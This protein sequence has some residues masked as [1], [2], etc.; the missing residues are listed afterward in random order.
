MLKLIGNENMKIY[1]RL[2]TWILLGIL[3]LGIILVAVVIRS[4]QHSDPNW[5]QTLTVS[6]AQIQ[7]QLQRRDNHIPAIG[8]QRMQEQIAVNQYDIQHNID[9]NHETAWTFVNVAQ[10]LSGLL[11]AFIVVIA[12][13]IVA[14]EFSSGTIKMLLTQTTTRSKILL[15]KYLAALLYAL[16]MTV[17]MFALSV[18][19]GGVFFGFS[20]ATMPNVFVQASGGLTHLGMAAYGLM[21]YGF[22]MIQ[23]I[24]TVT[25]AFMISAIFRSSALAITI[26]ILAFL[27]GV[28]LVQ[29]LSSY[30]WVKYILFA[31]TDLSQYVVGGPVIHGMTAGFSI[32]MLIAYFVVMIGLSW[33]IFLKR[34]VAYT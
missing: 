30:A 28:S 25:I 23:V 3:A 7:Q 10:H 24:V 19:V 12:G 33:L 18:L 6:N 14:G 34:D 21:Q 11:I 1:T 17:A 5:K 22:L 8:V 15:S 4:H 31:N 9:P 20:G 2:R 13:D 29:A 27:I 16:L 26:S 32:T